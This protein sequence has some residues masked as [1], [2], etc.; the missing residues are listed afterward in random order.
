[1]ERRCERVAGIATWVDET[2]GPICDGKGDS[3]RIKQRRREAEAGQVT[4]GGVERQKTLLERRPGYLVSERNIPAI[5]YDRAVRLI[6]K[7]SATSAGPISK[8][9]AGSGTPL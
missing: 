5:L 6:R 2:V 4:G 9:D 1:L 3:L 8:N 7:P